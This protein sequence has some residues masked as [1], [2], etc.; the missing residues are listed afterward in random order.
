VPVPPEHA[1]DDIVTRTF[2]LSGCSL[3]SLTASFEAIRQMAKTKDGRQ[4]LNKNFR[5][6]PDSQVEEEGDGERLLGAIKDVMEVS[7]GIGSEK[8]IIKK[9]EKR[10]PKNQ[11][12][13]PRKF[14]KFCWRILVQ[15]QTRNTRKFIEN[16]HAKI[17]KMHIQK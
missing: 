13:S 14:R 7:T 4:F 6:A 10:P 1:Y 11:I 2:L 5:L 15:K 17:P 3:G 12:D 16:L 8:S 9:E